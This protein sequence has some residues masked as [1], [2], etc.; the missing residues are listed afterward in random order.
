MKYGIHRV[1]TVQ[2]KR[3]G[4]PFLWK[5]AHGIQQIRVRGEFLSKKSVFHAREELI[6]EVYYTTWMDRKPV[7]LLHTFPTKNGMCTRMVKTKYDRWQRQEYTRPTII[8]V[9]N[10]G[11]VGTD[12]SGDQRMEVY[13]PKL[14]TITWIPRV[15]CHFINAAIVNS[16]I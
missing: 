2:K 13:W 3:K 5:P 11:M 1:D 14:K 9:Y 4:V 7:A 6:E 10:K 8:P 12:D 16:F 15:L